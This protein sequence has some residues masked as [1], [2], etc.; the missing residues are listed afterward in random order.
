MIVLTSPALMERI[1]AHAERFGIEIYDYI[2]QVDLSVRRFVLNLSTDSLKELY[3]S[4][5]C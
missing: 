5:I 4:C 1:Q 2:N 3:L